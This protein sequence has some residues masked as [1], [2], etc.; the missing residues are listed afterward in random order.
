MQ[1]YQLEL[2]DTFAGEANYCW[3][4][5]MIIAIP[6]NASKLASVRAIKKALGLNGVRSHVS[7]FGD[8]W[9]IR[10]RGLCQIA[11]ANWTDEIYYNDI[12]ISYNENGLNDYMF[13][14]DGKLY[15]FATLD[16]AKTKIDKFLD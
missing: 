3:V 8:M 14:L 6:D 10:P 1:H 9:E 16:E 13:K 15:A 12:P 4:K 7:D 11:F 2:T 5:R